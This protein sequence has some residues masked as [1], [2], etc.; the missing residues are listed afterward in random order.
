MSS[1]LDRAAAL[2][3]ANTRTASLDG[4]RFRFTV[5]SGGRYPF[6]WFWDSCFHAIVWARIDPARGADE[7]RSLLAWQ[8]DDGFVPHV[9]FWDE[10]LVPRFSWQYLESRGLLDVLP[11]RRPRVTAMIQ[12]PVLA[13]AVEAVVEAGGDGFLDEA[14][15]ALGHYYRFLESARDPD[16]DGLISII[17]QFESGLDFSPAYDP[18]S[19]RS[20]PTPRRLG[21]SARFPQVLN[22]LVGYDERAVFTVNRRHRE[23]VLVNSVYADGLRALARL[24]GR[25]REEEL[26]RWAESAAARVLGALLDRCY[27]ERRGLFFNLDG[28][29]ERRAD[30][31][32]T[33]IS[34][35]PLLLADLPSDVASRLVEH[36]TDPSEFW[37]PF[38]VPSV[39]LDERAFSSRSLVDGSRRIWRGPCSLSTNWLLWLGLGRHGHSELADV[40][41]ERSRELVVHGGFNEFFD[42]LSA[43]AVGEPE[44]GWATLAAVM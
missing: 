40:L 35:S 6:Q 15:P 7:L 17:S 23:D 13:Q 1:L 30:R 18:P 31:V 39:A 10:S 12:P 9:I 36:L 37:A 16:R 14:L 21:L 11:G 41:A 8:R 4:R 38:P 33:I 26:E 20:V 27:D 34:L 44:F 28:P 25:A 24:A 22:K 2:L 29:R 43:E 32:K 5:P 19:R 42:P 3:R